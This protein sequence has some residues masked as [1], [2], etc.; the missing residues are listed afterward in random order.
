MTALLTDKNIVIYGAGG[1]IGRG[2]A[3]TFARE[4]ANL[5]LAGRTR[6][7]VQKVAVVN[8]VS[9][10]DVQATAYVD[11]T[12]AG[13]LAPITA[14]L[15]ASFVI[16]RAAA[17]EMVR[18]GSGVILAITSGSSR[19]TMP[20][21]GGTVPPTRRP[22]PSCATS[23]PRSGRTACA[24]SASGRPACARRSTSTTTPTRR[25]SGPA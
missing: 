11:M 6:A 4:G 20:M 14:G 9:R 17:R 13:F 19:G 5:H 25:A 21:M 7:S 18:R 12:T 1:G 24:C 16:A 3:R 22:R 10:G 2:M 15:A 8:L 23:R